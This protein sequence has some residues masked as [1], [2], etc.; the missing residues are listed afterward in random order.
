MPLLLERLVAHLVGPGGRADGLTHESPLPGRLLS[1]V[2]SIAIQEGG[3][4]VWPSLPF[5]SRESAKVGQG[6]APRRPPEVYDADA[7]LVVHQPVARLPVAM[8]WH[9]HSGRVIVSGDDAPQATLGLGTDPM[10][11]VEP[12][13]R[14]GVSILA[15]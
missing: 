2:A 3:L 4:E 15:S 1:G 14:L 12:A 10:L 8:C 5:L 7:T 6:R 13:E 11:P 9:E